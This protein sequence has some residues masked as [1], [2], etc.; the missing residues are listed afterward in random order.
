MSPVCHFFQRCW[1]AVLKQFLLH[2]EPHSLLEPFQSAYRKCHSTETALLVNDLLQ[3]ADS[4]HVSILSLLD[5]SAA[6]DTID[7]D[8]LIKRLHTTFRCSG[9]VM[10]WFTYYLSFHSVCFCWSRINSI[11]FEMCCATGF[12]SGTSLI[13]FVHTVSWHCHLSIRPLIPHF[14]R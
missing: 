9:T 4:D 14:C 3:A 5:L 10:D 6:F 7:H 13:Y 11:C 1:S 8:I 12:L 2:L